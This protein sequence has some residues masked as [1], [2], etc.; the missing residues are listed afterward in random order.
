MQQKAGKTRS[1]LSSTNSTTNKN[2][3]LHIQLS[4]SRDAE[5][6][7]QCHCQYHRLCLRLPVFLL[8]QKY[9]FFSLTADSKLLSESLLLALLPL[10]TTNRKQTNV[11][12]ANEQR[13]DAETNILRIIPGLAI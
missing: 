4:L 6:L 5:I 1:V 9:Q 12:V 3:V 2:T 11:C 10:S 7:F 8:D 13:S